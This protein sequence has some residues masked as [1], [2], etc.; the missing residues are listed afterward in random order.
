MLNANKICNFDINSSNYE[1]LS[2]NARDLL[3]RLLEIDPI[4]RITAVQAL[5]HE[6]FSTYSA[7][8]MSPC[9]NE[10]KNITELF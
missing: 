8:S 1:K 4:K 2:P 10:N 5:S 7:H 6:F 3:W 9:E